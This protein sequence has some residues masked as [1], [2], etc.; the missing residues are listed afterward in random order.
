M[1]LLLVRH[2]ESTANVNKSIYLH[3]AD[4]KIAVTAKGVEQADE[5][6]KKVA[7]LAKGSV[8]VYISPYKRTRETW[9]RMSAFV[10]ADNVTESPSLRE[11]EHATFST[12]G[13]AEA[14]RV[15]AKAHGKMWWRYQNAESIANVYDRVLAFHN[16]ILIKKQ[17]ALAPQTVVVVAHEIVL[18]MYCYLLKGGKYEDYTDAV[19]ENGS[20][21]EV[22]I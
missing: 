2:G 16:H 17:D 5:A 7:A 8:A 6:G 20:V 4:H 9:N 10:K 18:K 14:A 22:E 21:T 3:T 19:F 12:L 15:M 11:Q 1:K 13:E